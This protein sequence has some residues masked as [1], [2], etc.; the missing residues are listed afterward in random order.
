V[1]TSTGDAESADS[2]LVEVAPEDTFPP[3]P[4]EG[5][6][7]VAGP[8]TVE[9]SWNPS[10]ESDTAG[11]HIYRGGARINA[12]LV[13]APAFTD[14]DVRTAQQHSYTVSSVDAKGNESAASA[15]VSVTI[16]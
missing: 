8:T 7:A 1:T 15:A 11:Y 5:L 4:P 16:P 10:P 12:E 13:V 6:R 3:S 14:K 2:S 9:L